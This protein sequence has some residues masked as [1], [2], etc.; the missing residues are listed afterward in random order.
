MMLILSTFSP[1]KSEPS[2]RYL[3]RNGSNRKHN[4]TMPTTPKPIPPISESDKLRFFSQISTIPTE[5]GCLEWT[6]GKGNKGYGQF[7]IGRR[8]FRAH[9]IAYFLA[10]GIDPGEQLVLHSCDN[11]ACCNPAHHFLGT[12]L[13]NARD[14]DFKGR[15]NTPRGG[16]H[17][18]AKLTETAIREIRE[19]HAAGESHKDIAMTFSMH[20]MAI[21]LIISRK[22]WKHVV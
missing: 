4:K 3:R 1:R 17:G 11:L 16:R 8:P 20:R 2:Q 13:D 15:G 10:N 19:R 21:S 7:N 22:S 5:Q 14:R 9:R 18:N 6:T 12:A